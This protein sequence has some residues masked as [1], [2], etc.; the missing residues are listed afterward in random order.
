MWFYKDKQTNI[1]GLI[2]FAIMNYD[3]DRDELLFMEHPFE[4]C[5]SAKDVAKFHLKQ[6]SFNMGHISSQMNKVFVEKI[7]RK[8]LEN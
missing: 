4:G 8:Y 5:K 7:L 3:F 2:D 1:G 6:G